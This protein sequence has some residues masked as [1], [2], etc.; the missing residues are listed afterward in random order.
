MDK[1]PSYK[2]RN[3]VFERMGVPVY[4]AQTRV[5][6]HGEDPETIDALRHESAKAFQAKWKTTLIVKLKEAKQKRIEKKIQKKVDLSRLA[7][8]EDLDETSQLIKKRNNL[9]LEI[10]EMKCKK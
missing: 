1:P 7:R 2:S 8:E 3:E 6:H 9:L 4:H 5:R 10:E